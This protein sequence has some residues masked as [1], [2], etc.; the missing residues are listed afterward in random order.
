MVGL[1]AEGPTVGSNDGKFTLKAIVSLS[2]A[3]ADALP[4]TSSPERKPAPPSASARRR[5]K[6]NMRTS[7]LPLKQI[8]M[9]PRHL[10]TMRQSS[11]SLRRV[12]PAPSAFPL[13]EPGRACERPAQHISIPCAFI[14]II[15]RSILVSRVLRTEETLIFRAR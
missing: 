8:A 9:R 10:E 1:T 15:P 7:D 12:S 6:L 11:R 5:S 3:C 2:L 13:R 14:Y 4:P